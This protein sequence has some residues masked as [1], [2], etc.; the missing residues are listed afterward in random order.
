MDDLKNILKKII[1]PIPIEIKLQGLNTSVFGGFDN[2]ILGWSKKLI[3]ST[4]DDMVKEYAQNLHDLFIDYSNINLKERHNRLK[5][6][7]DIIN[8]LSQ[9]INGNQILDLNDDKL[10]IINNRVDQKKIIRKDN[11]S[12]QI[13]LDLR[14]K[15]KLKDNSKV[16]K[17]VKKKESDK[18]DIVWKQPIQYIKG[19]GE[20][21]AKRLKK[22][23]V[24]EVK[25]LLY[26][27]PRD[28]N[29]WSKF[30]KI[31][32]LNSGEHITVQ[33]KI[34]SVNEIKPRSG[35]KIIKIGISDGTGVLYGVW[36]NQSYIKKVLKKGDLFLFSGEVK[37]SYGNFEINNPH[38]EQVDFQDNLNTARIVPIYPTTKGI[39]QK[40]LRRVIKNT[41]DKYLIGIDDF[42]PDMI[43]D[44]YEFIALNEAISTIHFPKSKKKLKNARKRFVYEELFILQ[45][46]LALR[47]SEAQ[48]EK[49]GIKHLKEDHLVEKFLSNLAFNLT[50]AQARVWQEIKSD[51]ESN[52]NMNRLLQGDVGAGKTVIATLALLKTVESGFQGAL[53][54]P[55]EILAEQHY[56][57]LKEELEFLDIEVGLLVGSLKTKEKRELLEKI[58][59]D[60]IDIVIGTHALIQE[61]INFSNLGLAI[62]DEQH[63]FGVKQR[64]TLQEKG[65]NPDVLVM[66]ATPIPRTLALTVYGDLDVS[67]IDELPPGRK[68]VITEWR[69]QQARDKIYSFVREEV[70]KG[71]QAYVVCPLVEESEKLDIES[72]TELSVRLQE[73]YFPD[74]KVGLLHGKMKASEKE[75]IMEEFRVGNINILVSTT[76]IEVGVNVPN[77]SIMII[78]DA[79]RFGLAQLHQLRGRVGRGKYQSYCILVS[80]PSTEEGVERMKIM[81]KSTDGFV[82]AEEDL[83]LRGPGEFFGT[84]QHG[85]PDLKIADILRDY[86]ILEIARK[87]AFALI[88][89]DPK[90]KKSENKRL[91]KILTDNFNYD[92]D[93]IDIS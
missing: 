46:I 60:E 52:K 14:K 74:L 58:E 92:F 71:R 77:S 78:E 20:Y 64:A 22:L 49:L 76:V 93:L 32:E 69:T 39:T 90:L 82:I 35:L 25:D 70:E 8:K 87:D 72:A 61:G 7:L 43:I 50:D 6:S 66:T 27:F 4:E 17:Q 63:R 5:E 36:F 18:K 80:D 23:G 11:D 68:P 86:K 83:H 15:T 54:A 26:Y 13:S 9:K 75:E 33:G 48:S 38:Y 21:W 1:K 12:Q 55:T 91:K 51:M 57:G 53:M 44:K 73:E 79:Q 28:Y 41:L 47:K 67:V 89:D 37:Y 84:R 42:L 3:E 59:N 56:L 40:K 81:T 2:Y 34:V 85:M 65:N 62:I 19:I 24:E 88:Q 45:L 30:K 29:D 31:S 16:K 10:Q